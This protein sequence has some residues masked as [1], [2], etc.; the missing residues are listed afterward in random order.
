MIYIITDSHIGN[1]RCKKERLYRLIQ[2]MAKDDFIIHSGDLIDLQ[3]MSL[4]DIIADNYDLIKI[5]LEKIKYYVIGN[6]DFPITKLMGIQLTK[7]MI[8]GYPQTITYIGGKKW[9]IV[10]GHY[11]GLLGRYFKIV[12]SMY[13]SKLFRKLSKWCMSNSFLSWLDK[14]KSIFSDSTKEKAIAK[15][16]ELK[17]D[18]VVCG[19]NHIPALEYI[20]CKH[21]NL[22]YANAGAYGENHI[23]YDI[24]KD[25][26]MLRSDHDA[27]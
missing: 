7:D 12:E 9:L 10:H 4:L 2:N 13:D 8:M 25:L 6:H 11:F 20:P 26:F 5:L 22:V 3:Y 15:A 19:H 23:I 14:I 27:I 17:C 16:I 18:V 24:N 1:K 21:G